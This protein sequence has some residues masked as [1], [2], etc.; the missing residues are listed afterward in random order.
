MYRIIDYVKL[1]GTHKNHRDQLSEA[2]ICI[3]NSLGCMQV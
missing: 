1:E 2:E 3:I